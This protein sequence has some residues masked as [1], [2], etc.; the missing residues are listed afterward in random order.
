MQYVLYPPRRDK[1]RPHA[2][3]EEGDRQGTLTLHQRF[4][5]Q[6]ELSTRHMH[7]QSTL[8]PQTVSE[9]VKL[10]G[11]GQKRSQ[12]KPEDRADREEEVKLVIML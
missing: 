8:P 12:V 1:V 2:R 9:I 11:K 10:R 6:S 3:P 5:H 4:L 7:A